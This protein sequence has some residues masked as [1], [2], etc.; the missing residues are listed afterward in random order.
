MPNSIALVT[1]FEPKLDEAYKYG[2][3]TIDLENE[4]LDFVG[5]HEVKIPKI[6]MDGLADYSRNNGFTAGSVNVEYETKVMEYDRGREFEVDDLDNEESLNTAFGKLTG[7]FIKQKVCPET[8]LIRFAK[9]ASMNNI[10][11]ANA[12][13]LSNGTALINAIE[14][15][16]AKMDDDEV[17]VDDRILY[18]SP[19][20]YNLLKLNAGT[21]FTPANATNVNFNFSTFDGMKIVKV[22]KGRFY[23][24]VTK[25]NTTTIIEPTVTDNKT[26]AINFMIVQKDAVTACSKRQKLRVFSPDENQDK[27]AW[28]MQYR[29]VHD[30]FG[31]DN[32]VAGIYLHPAVAA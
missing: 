31:Y 2:C 21:R 6:S 16:E 30:L 28:K 15:A 25:N 22:P 8:D 17:P 20:L 7:Q 27:D 26:Q 3:L 4:D 1:R 9:M 10:S 5:T 12:A 14:T 24:G 11:K 19:T 13:T 29:L 23:T 18:I 32:K